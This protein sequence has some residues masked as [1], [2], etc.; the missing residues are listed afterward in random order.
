MMMRVALKVEAGLS[1]QLRKDIA[2]E[3]EQV[4]C[5]QGPFLSY[6]SMQDNGV[7]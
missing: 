1:F 4:L 5:E 6:G 7:L 3:W 2:Q